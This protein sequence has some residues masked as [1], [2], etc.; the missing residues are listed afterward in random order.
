MGRMKIE[1]AKTTAKDISLL[2]EVGFIGLVCAGKDTLPA[3]SVANRM[4]MV[5]VIE[6]IWSLPG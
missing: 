1:L 2:E 4:M 3:Q 6:N 5:G